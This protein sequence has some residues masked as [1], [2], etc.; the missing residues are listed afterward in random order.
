VLPFPELRSL[1]NIAVDAKGALYVVD[2]QQNQVL[3]LDPGST[4]PTVLPFIGLN[5]PVSVAVGATGEVY[6]VDDGNRRIVKLGGAR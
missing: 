5:G 6:V 3:K 4:T 2:G 1:I